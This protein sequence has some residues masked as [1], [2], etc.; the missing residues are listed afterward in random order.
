MNSCV[1]IVYD[2][3]IGIY[4]DHQTLHVVLGLNYQA[5]HG[6]AAAVWV[7]IYT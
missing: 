4:N 5:I 1:I 6:N 2:F 3:A 7:S